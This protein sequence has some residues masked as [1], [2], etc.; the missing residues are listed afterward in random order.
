MHGG[1]KMAKPPYRPGHA[2]HGLFGVLVRS[3]AEFCTKGVWRPLYQYPFDHPCLSMRTGTYKNA[4]NIMYIHAAA[5]ADKTDG[6]ET[7]STLYASVMEYS[8]V[9]HTGMR[10]YK[11]SIGTIPVPVIVL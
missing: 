6:L 5:P 8:T 2:E 3:V 10:H 1:R 11:Y 4:H 9:R 7:P